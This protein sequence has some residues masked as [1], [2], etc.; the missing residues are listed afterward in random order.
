MLGWHGRPTASRPS[1]KATSSARP[2]SRP[3]PRATGHA[4]NPPPIPRPLRWWFFLSDD[5]SARGLGL[6][7][8]FARSPA[9][10]LDRLARPRRPPR[11]GHDAPVAR[12]HDRDLDL[13][14]GQGTAGAV[15][16]Q[17][18]GVVAVHAWSPPVDG[19]RREAATGDGHLLA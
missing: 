6:G 12:G 17:P 18:A 14:A 10:V 2:S 16:R 1:S 8:P 11:P 5:H 19:P 3:P 9:D 7:P 13:A 4:L 15:T